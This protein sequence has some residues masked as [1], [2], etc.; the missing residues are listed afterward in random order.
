MGTEGAC[1]G[2]RQGGSKKPPLWVL[3][4]R[5]QDFA[6]GEVRNPLWVQ[7]ARVQD[8]AKGK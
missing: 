1:R 8:L 2:F 5:V 6:K 7:E 4:A 3:E